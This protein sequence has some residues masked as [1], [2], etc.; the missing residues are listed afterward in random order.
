MFADA[1]ITMMSIFFIWDWLIDV[2]LT[3]RL[4]LSR[5]KMRILLVV[6]AMALFSHG[7]CSALETR[8]V[9]VE[10]HE[11]DNFDF[12]D[13]KMWIPS[14]SLPVQLIVLTCGGSQ[15]GL[16][17]INASGWR[18]LARSTNSGLLTCLFVSHDNSARWDLA[19]H[20][21]GR[22]LLEALND[23]AS[24]TGKPQIRKMSLFFLG[25]SQG[26]Q[27]GYHF[28][29]WKPDQTK[30]FI[31]IKGGYHDILQAKSASKVPGLFV[32][33]ALDE[34]FRID[35]V[36]KVFLR[37]RASNA[38]WCLAVDPHSHHEPEPCSDLASMFIDECA[39]TKI[40]SVS[41]TDS[42]T[43]SAGKS[44]WFP[45]MRFKNAWERFNADGGPKILNTLDFTSEAQHQLGVVEPTA[46]ILPPVHSTE[47]SLP[48]YLNLDSGNSK[49]W[50]EA[51]ILSRSYL[52]T[53]NGR[54]S[55]DSPKP[56]S[57]RFNPKSLPLGFFVGDVPIRFKL[58]GRPVLGGLNVPLTAKILG[59]VVA[60]PAAIYL[61][62]LR[63]G[64]WLR[65]IISIGSKSGRLVHYRSSSTPIGIRAIAP[66]RSSNPIQ[67]AYM[68]DLAKL[69]SPNNLTCSGTI[70]T[71][72]ETD[73]QWT[74]RIPFMGT[75]IEP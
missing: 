39:N 29:A 9:Q 25:A 54:T 60:S 55:S 19:A 70:V 14:G 59:D 43:V 23:F 15:S 66:L 10:G 26:G 2:R 72:V 4:Y 34:P 75:F 45:S 52:I 47:E 50:D 40:S 46:L 49:S 33:G 73:R 74:L 62:S 24:N 21:T 28:A 3:L 38:P 36:R 27:F 58:H 17:N 1:T 31:S 30:G 64:G 63:P 44:S 18:S 16:S 65:V 12:A 42:S 35:N 67:I 13:F 48:V 57:F 5:I 37:G 32:V 41:D 51:E 7:Y 20:G 71:C 22:A 56:L 68:F 11:K 6:T 8:E 53:I 61:G 69:V